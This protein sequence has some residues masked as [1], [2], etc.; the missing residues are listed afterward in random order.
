MAGEKSGAA[1][2]GKRITW[3]YASGKKKGFDWGPHR[4]PFRI[5][6]DQFTLE[7]EETGEGFAYRRKYAG[8]EVEKFLFFNRGTVLLSPVEPLSIPSVISPNLMIEFERSVV[9]EPKSSSVVFLTFPLEIAVVLKRGR[10]EE[11]I[12]DLFSL[13]KP[14][15][16]LYGGV[17]EGLVCKY[18]RSP[19]FVSAPDLNPLELGVM[20]LEVHNS[21]SRWLE[22]NRAVFSAYGMRIFYSPQL[23]SLHAAI[24]LL[25]EK[26][27]E[28]GFLDKP[29][30]AGMSKAIE[31]F[32]S[33]LLGQQGKVAMEEGY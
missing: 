19:V 3:S 13:S 12:L 4:L 1:V 25:N 15:Y 20:K 33:K 11:H 9:V 23:V 31:V 27:A 7:F 10:A 5:E 6:A 14:K 17:K 8:E 2:K 24:R 22:V 18:W 29:H 16:T 30:K 21:N 32:S 26:T 28:T